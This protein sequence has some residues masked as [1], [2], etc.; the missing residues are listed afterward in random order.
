LIA[1]NLEGGTPEGGLGLI[2]FNEITISPDGKRAFAV[3]PEVGV[4]FAIDVASRKVVGSVDVGERTHG[5]GVT[6]DGKEVWT[7]NNAGSVSIVDVESLKL[8]ATIPMKEHVGDLTYTH[9]AFSIDGTK[10]YLA[11][12]ED[13][14]VIDVATRQLLATIPVEAGP[15]EISLED[16]YNSVPE[17]ERKAPASNQGDNPESTG[18][19][20]KK[21]ESKAGGVTIAAT[22]EAPESWDNPGTLEFSV[23]MDTHSG[24][25]TKY[26]LEE[27]TTVYVDGNKVEAELTWKGDSESSHHRS[28]TLSVELTTPIKSSFELK[29]EGVV[30][31]E[32]VLEWTRSK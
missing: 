20:V 3:G 30:V 9:V 22:L 5:V 18:E 7:A 4:I 21:Q 24:D 32:R 14:T 27:I 31:K 12:A 28:G 11:W 16:Y 17:I 23:V 8:L 26:D 13:I 2:G 6:R 1:R 15:H 29:I 25:L 19:F 10:A